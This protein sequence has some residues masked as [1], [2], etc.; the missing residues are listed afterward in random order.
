MPRSSSEMVTGPTPLLRARSRCE[1]AFSFLKVLSL[2]PSTSVNLSIYTHYSC[3]FYTKQGDNRIK[4][5]SGWA[6][7]GNEVRAWESECPPPYRA[8]GSYGYCN[9]YKLASFALFFST[10]QPHTDPPILTL[11]CLV[12]MRAQVRRLSSLR[13]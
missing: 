1:R 9:A 10:R 2:V 7:G 12:L 11:E 6:A 3:I 4:S 13:Q 8:I 5:L